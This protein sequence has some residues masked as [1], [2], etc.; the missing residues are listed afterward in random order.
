[1][2]SVKLIRGRSRLSKAIKEFKNSKEMQDLR[3]V[4]DDNKDVKVLYLAED[5]YIDTMICA[6]ILK[7][8]KLEKLGG[9]DCNGE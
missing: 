4:F 3:K 7:R 6:A 1:M 2:H 9:K 5:S 8:G